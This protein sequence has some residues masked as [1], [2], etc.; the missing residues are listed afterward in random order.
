MPKRSLFED[1]NIALEAML[2][3]APLPSATAELDPLMRVAADLRGMPRDEFKSLLKTNLQKETSMATQTVPFKREGFHTITPYLIVNEADK[4]IDFVK[5]AFGAE[6]LFRD[7]GSAGGIHCEARIGDSKLMLGGGG[8]WRGTPT[9]AH[10]HLYVDDADAVYKRAISA[11]ATSLYEPSDMPY[12]D[13]EGGVQDVFG[14]N[15]YIGTVRDRPSEG[16]STVTL[17]LLVSEAARL[18]DFLQQAF[19][20]EVVARHDE[21][22]GRVAHAQVRLG[23]SIVET[24]DAHGQFKPIPSTVYMYVP[25]V[26]ALYNRALGAGATSVT[27]PADQPYGDRNAGVRDPFGNTWYLA[28][29]IGEAPVK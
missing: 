22:S 13:R 26:D 7:V 18:I 24:S 19:A 11:G 25:D 27:A 20:A 9:P 4:L 6:E 15:W 21:P 17:G 5:Q 28:T 8:E 3:G 29:H 12:G 23:D 14:N 10:I 2:T 16:L 1:L